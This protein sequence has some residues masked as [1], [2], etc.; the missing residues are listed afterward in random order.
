MTASSR[1]ESRTNLTRIDEARGNNTVEESDLLIN[2]KNVDWQTHTYHSWH[3]LKFTGPVLVCG[4]CFLW[5]PVWFPIKF[6][7]SFYP[8][9]FSMTSVQLKLLKV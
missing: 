2:E 3:E 6:F 8:D 4:G 9:L 5:T 7:G 1:K